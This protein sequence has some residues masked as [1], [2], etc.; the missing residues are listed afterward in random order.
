MIHI[1]LTGGIA[2]GK[3]S[4]AALFEQ[5]GVMVVDADQAARD[6]VL[7]GNSGLHALIRQFGSSLLSADGSLNRPL[8]RQWIFSD[9]E[10]RAVVEGILHPLIAAHLNQ[11]ALQAESSNTPPPY[12]I[13]MIPLLIEKG[14]SYALDRILLIDLPQPL[15]VER[16]MLRDQISATE[17]QAILDAQASRESR[18]RAADDIILN[19]APTDLS[20]GVNRLHQQYLQLAQ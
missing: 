6:V 4:A 13:Y 10:K 11:Q 20:R 9:P 14:D 2:S 5:K 1:G 8:L 18:Q 15:Q 17:A 19:I 12:L 7:P 16:V 3:S